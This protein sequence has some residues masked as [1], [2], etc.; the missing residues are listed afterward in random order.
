MGGQN[1]GSVSLWSAADLTPLG[2]FPVTGLGNV[3]YGVASDGIN[4]WVT[5]GNSPGQLARF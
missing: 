3:P 1:S 5:L 2:N 4:F